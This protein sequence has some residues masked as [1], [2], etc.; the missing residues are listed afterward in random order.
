MLFQSKTD[1]KEWNPELTSEQLHVLKDKG[2]EAPGTGNETK[3]DSGCGWPAF[4]GEIKGALKYKK[5]FSHGMMR[6]EIMCAKCGGHLGHE[7]KGE[8]WNK[9]LNLPNDSRHCVN[10]L[11]LNFKKEE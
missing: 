1:K 9:R 5:D 11:S 8:G 6:T 2:T 7:F 10:S 3:F 4:N